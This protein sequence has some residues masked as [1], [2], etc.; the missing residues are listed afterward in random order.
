MGKRKRSKVR[1][2]WI[3]A[4][5]T[6]AIRA[7]ERLLARMSFRSGARLFELITTLGFEFIPRVRKRALANLAIA[8]PDRSL[9]W[10]RRVMWRFAR[11]LGW[12]ANEVAQTERIMTDPRLRRQIDIREALEAL[13]AA[14]VGQTTGAFIAASHQGNGDLISVAIAEARVGMTAAIRA[15]PNPYFER[16]FIESRLRFGRPSVVKQRFVREALKVLKNKGIACAMIDQD[17]GRKHGIFVPYFGKLASTPPG[18]AAI[19]RKAGVPVFVMA[20]I[21]TKPRLPAVTCHVLGP[22]ELTRTDDKDADIAAWTAQLTAAIEAF[23]RRWPEQVLWVHRRWKSR[24]PEEGS[25]RL[26]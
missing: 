11:Q 12:S 14:G 13:D 16:R 15:I 4:I 18:A 24:P 22:L 8:F 20:A 17:A 9:A 19:A 10:R 3:V 6:A 2:A 1:K 7:A 23:A 5:E 26:A 21:R 25:V